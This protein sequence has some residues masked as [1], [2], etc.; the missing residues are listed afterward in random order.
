MASWSPYDSSDS[1]DSSKTLTNS[2]VYDPQTQ[3]PAPDSA[4]IT[5]FTYYVHNSKGSSVLSPYE[6]VSFI[7]ATLTPDA[8]I[9]FRLACRV[10]CP[11]YF[12]YVTSVFVTLYSPFVVR[13]Q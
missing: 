13:D 2:D 4:H 10:Y 12:F 6:P 11:T 8:L 5:G 3:L 9:S 7:P 1:G